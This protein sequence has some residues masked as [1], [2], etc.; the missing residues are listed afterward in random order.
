M[1]TTPE[2]I[3]PYGS[4]DSKTEQVERMFDSIAPATL[5]Q[6]LDGRHLFVCRR[7]DER[8]SPFDIKIQLIFQLMI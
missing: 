1:A 4:A 5:Q 2:T 6:L 8:T 3:T 7:R